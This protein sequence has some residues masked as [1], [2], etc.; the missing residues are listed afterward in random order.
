MAPQFQS[1]SSTL[2]FPYLWEIVDASFDI[3]VSTD[4]DFIKIIFPTKW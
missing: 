4:T 1:L 3:T 2:N